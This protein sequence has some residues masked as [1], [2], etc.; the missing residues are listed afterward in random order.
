MKNCGQ[1]TFSKV[2]SNCDFVPPCAL[3][4]WTRHIESN[5]KFVYCAAP[6]LALNKGR[7]TIHILMTENT[8]Y[9][10]RA[11]L[12]SVLPQSFK[13]SKWPGVI[14]ERETTY[15][16]LPFSEAY[17]LRWA[18]ISI[19]QTLY[20]RADDSQMSRNDFRGVGI[21]FT[22][23]MWPSDDQEFGSDHT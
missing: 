13:I 15:F 21:I 1:S 14:D 6:H 3:L 5:S 7:N 19:V 4:A 17:A 20:C 8:Q 16:V 18:T 11:D 9:T 10:L 2:R 23:S 22:R 12:I